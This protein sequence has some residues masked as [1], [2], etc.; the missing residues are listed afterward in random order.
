MQNAA[1]PRP[2]SFMA[3]PYSNGNRTD[4]E[5]LTGRRTRTVMA[6]T[7][8]DLNIP[9]GALW[10]SMWEH[11]RIRRPPDETPRASVNDEFFR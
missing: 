3:P 6:A 1:L 11:R 7:S 5:Y 4:Y 2:K 10:V 9:P 8:M